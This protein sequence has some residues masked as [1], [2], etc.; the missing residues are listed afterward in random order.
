MARTTTVPLEKARKNLLAIWLFG[1]CVPLMLL[2]I[3]TIFN[4]YQQGADTQ[5]WGWFTPLIFP[6]ISL[7]VSTLGESAMSGKRAKKY[8]NKDFYG[9]TKLLSFFYLLVVSCVIFLEPLSK[10]DPVPLFTK[11]NLFIS[12]IQA[13]VVA[14]LSYLFYTA[15]AGSEEEEPA[16]ARAKG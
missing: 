14:A 9:I 5:V 4:K 7:M 16:E 1:S 11:S 12:P 6:T 2:I 13:I 10:L 8:V 3:N 15:K